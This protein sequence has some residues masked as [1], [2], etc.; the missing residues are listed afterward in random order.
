[1]FVIVLA[2]TSFGR[3]ILIAKWFS[4]WERFFFTMW[5]NFDLH[6]T[7]IL[8][9]LARHA[10][11]IDSEAAASNFSAAQNFRVVAWL[12]FEAARTERT[13]GIFRQIKEWLCPL[14]FEYDFQR[15]EGTLADCANTGQWLLG[16]G[17]FTSWL[18]PDDASSILW[19]SGIPGSGKIFS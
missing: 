18:D 15:C 1:M 16:N 4:A 5:S 6:F 8:N 11:L 12:E 7:H 9:R 10:D 17:K 2:K 14:S 13:K 19:L 3:T